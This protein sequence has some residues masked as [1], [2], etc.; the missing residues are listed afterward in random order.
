MFSIDSA[1]MSPQYQVDT[2]VIVQPVEADE[3]ELGDVIT[4]VFN[5][6]G[7]LVTHRVIDIDTQSR[8][9]KTK[10]DANNSED[11]MPVFWD[12]LVGKVVF[13]IPR[14]GKPLRY[15]TDP[16]NRYIVVGAIAIIF[17]V[18]LGWDVVKRRKK[19][20]T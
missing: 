5:E 20:H 4:Y 15:L 16:Q 18:S 17:V 8:T 19:K 6:N 11:P 9:F 12:N 14:L 10:G 3:I 13:A 7:I 2:L 1:S